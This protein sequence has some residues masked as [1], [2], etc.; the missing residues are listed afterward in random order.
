MAKKLLLNW[1][2]RCTGTHG[3]YGTEYVGYELT[4]PPAHGITL[5]ELTVRRPIEK[6]PYY[7]ISKGTIVRGASQTKLQNNEKAQFGEEGVVGVVEDKKEEKV[8]LQF[9]R[10]FE[11]KN[12][13]PMSVLTQLLPNPSVAHG[14]I[15]VLGNPSTLSERNHTMKYVRSNP[16]R[17]SY[18]SITVRMK[19][20]DRLR[21]DK[22]LA[23][24]S[25]RDRGY[26]EGSDYD[27]ETKQRQ[28]FFRVSRSPTAERLTKVLRA[29][30]K[31]L[32]IKGTVVALQV[33]NF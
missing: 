23:A 25:P 32:K 9:L 14:L 11:K 26:M 8:I 27:F 4:P 1:S 18:H 24:L 12:L 3:S 22:I 33:T 30:L 31:K 5:I 21:E 7:R 19:G 13:S 10:W 2:I 15:D 28:L 29:I 17:S 16:R 6:D 20:Y